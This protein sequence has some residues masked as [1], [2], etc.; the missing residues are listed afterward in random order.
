[1]EHT[2]ADWVVG[3]SDTYYGIMAVHLA[4]IIGCNSLVDAYDNYESY[5]KWAKPLHILYRRAIANAD[6]VTAAG[7]QLLEFITKNSTRNNKSVI[8]MAADELFQPLN[9]KLCRIQLGLPTDRPIIGY[10]GSAMRNR[11]IHLLYKAIKLVAQRR[12]DVLFAFSGRTDASFKRLDNMRHVGYLDDQLM[13]I[14]INCFDLAIAIND[15]TSFGEYSYP[16]KIYEATA[17]KVPVLSSKHAPTEWI[18]RGSGHQLF[19]LG[20]TD[21][22]VDKIIQSLER[23]KLNPISLPSWKNIANDF[24]L[25]FDLER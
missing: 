10:C 18:L 19:D 4:D 5:I 2:S 3:F 14:F 7:P 16:I 17:C 9:K 6:A 22:L 15:K 8:P 13:P 23:N 21:T 11:G 25:C 12:P 24:E 1:M 20:K